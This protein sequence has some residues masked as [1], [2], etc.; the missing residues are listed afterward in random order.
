MKN[1]AILGHYERNLGKKLG[2]LWRAL[3][4]SLSEYYGF[5]FVEEDEVVFSLL[6][7]FFVFWFFVYVALG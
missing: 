5:V 2:I 6:F 1:C 7:S 4:L 3:S